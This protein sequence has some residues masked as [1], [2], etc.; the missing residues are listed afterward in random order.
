MS[1]KQRQLVEHA[2]QYQMSAQEIQAQVIDFAY[3]N[4]HFEDD[5]VTREGVAR[6][7]AQVSV[8]YDGYE[9]AVT[10]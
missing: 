7:A 5:R 4:G 10:L 2:R 6:A 1:N 8:H 3:A 9:V